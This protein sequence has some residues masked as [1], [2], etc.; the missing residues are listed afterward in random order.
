MQGPGVRGPGVWDKGGCLRTRGSEARQRGPR[1]QTQPDGWT[2]A[3]VFVLP[4]ALTENPAS[5]G[6]WP[7]PGT[8]VPGV[9]LAAR[10]MP[11]AASRQGVHGGG[12]ARAEGG[13]GAGAGG[14]QGRGSV[15]RGGGAGP[16][17][18]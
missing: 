15:E 13:A 4:G 9:G 11:G 16:D 1:A 3:V 7:P 17:G 12:G 2:P 5:A 6:L 14:G 18:D 8:C 10:F